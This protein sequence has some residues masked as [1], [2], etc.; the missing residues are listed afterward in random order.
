MWGSRCTGI[1]RCG[2]R[3]RSNAEGSH[4][5]SEV[6]RGPSHSFRTA[7]VLGGDVVDAKPEYVV[8]DE[9]AVAARF[10]HEAL[11]ERLRGIV[12]RLKEREEIVLG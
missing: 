8:G 9:E 5:G 3:S 4:L 10:Q 6:A 2:S 11:R 1:G 7:N 12:V